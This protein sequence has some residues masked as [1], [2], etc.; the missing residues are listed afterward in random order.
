MDHDHVHCCSIL[1]GKVMHT[2]TSRMLRSIPPTYK[3]KFIPLLH[4]IHLDKTVRGKGKISSLSHSSSDRTN[5]IPMKLSSSTHDTCTITYYTGT[6]TY[7]QT[8]LKQDN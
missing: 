5:F 8:P 4:H 6:Y 3:K 1:E 7:S 2:I